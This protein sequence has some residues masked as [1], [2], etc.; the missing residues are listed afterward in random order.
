MDNYK[1]KVLLVEMEK[2]CLALGPEEFMELVQETFARALMAVE[3]DTDVSQDAVSNY[4]LH[5]VAVGLLISELENR[6]TEDA[7]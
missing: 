2:A 6:S 1:E 5:E 4:A 3:D 7:A